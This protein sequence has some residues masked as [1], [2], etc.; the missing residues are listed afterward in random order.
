MAGTLSS[1]APAIPC[2]PAILAG[3]AIL[4]TVNLPASVFRAAPMVTWRHQAVV[5]MAVLALQAPAVHR[6]VALLLALAALLRVLAALLRALVVL[7]LLAAA[8]PRP[9]AALLAALAVSVKNCVSGT[10]TTRVHSVKTKIADGAGKIILAV[11][12]VLPVKAKVV[13]AV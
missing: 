3:M 10:K 8:P 6:L 5:L 1:L 4:A 13:V 11:S 2:Q 9:P 12:A 7:H